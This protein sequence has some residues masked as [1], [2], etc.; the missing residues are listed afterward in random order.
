M[1]ASDKPVVSIC[2]PTHNDSAVVG[3]ALRS[4]L[5][6]SYARVEILVV[7]NHS[8]DDTWRI[9]TGI[10]SED[11]R[12]RCIRNDEDIG[13]ARN[14]NACLTAASGEYVLIL[15]SDDAL[16]DGCA[17]LLAAA[18]REH[19]DAVLAA[20]GRTMTDLSLRPQRVLRAR[21]RRAEITSAKLLRECFAHGNRIG[22]PSAVMFRRLMAGRGFNSDYSQALDLE[23]WFHLLGMGSAVLLPEPCCSI[24]QHEK[25]NTR[26][27]IRSGRIVEDK[28]LLFRQ[29]AAK[30]DP[31]L[32][33]WE[34]LV[35]D[36][37]MASSVARSNAIGGMID[38][39]EITEL[40]YPTVFFR[41][42][43]PLIGIGWKLRGALAPQRL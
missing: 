30:L 17:E 41:L 21:H 28:R 33:W 13:M 35:W 39:T 27:N 23:M 3:D 1:H 32:T 11:H 12:V 43:S 16:E 10:A 19:P 6:Q 26:R 14:F 7:D 2:I 22:E 37:R 38:A 36:A 9:V 34:R 15:C 4:A 29:Y 25:Q 5:R 31:T 24:R 18:L 40:F 8:T 42:L 20:C